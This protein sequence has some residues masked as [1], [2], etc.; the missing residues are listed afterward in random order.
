MN[1]NHI[2]LVTHKDKDKDSNGL[3]HVN[4]PFLAAKQPYK[5]Q[6]LAFASDFASDF[7]SYFGRH[8]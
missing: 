5:R 3:R 4:S 2:S 6:G 8:F 7:A 1:K